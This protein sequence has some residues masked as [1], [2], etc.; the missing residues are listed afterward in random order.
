[1][2]HLMIATMCLLGLSIAGCS[3]YV[4]TESSGP[5]NRSNFPVGQPDDRATLMEIDAAA[6]LSF[7]SE[8]NKTLTAIASRP[9][10]SARAQNYLVTKGVRSLDFESSRLNVMLAL[11]NNPH[12]LAEGKLAILENINLLSFSSSQTKVLEAIN[13]RGYVPEER[14]LYAEPPSYPDPEIQQP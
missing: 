5:D 7:D 4:E 10:L 12:F 11:V 9:Y 8:R 2:R 6:N 3:V 1:M 13:R 14:Q